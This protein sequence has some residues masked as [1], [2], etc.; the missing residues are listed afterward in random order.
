MLESRK[1]AVAHEISELES[2]LGTIR[3]TLAGL[4]KQL[5]ARFGGNINLE[6]N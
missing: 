4:K 2:Q 1:D 5:Y 6:E 3:Q